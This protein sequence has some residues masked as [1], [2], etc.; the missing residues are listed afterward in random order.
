MAMQ[1]FR[2]QC[3][4]DTPKNNRI[5]SDHFTGCHGKGHMLASSDVNN[6]ICSV[7]IFLNCVL[8]VGGLF[9]SSKQP[10]VQM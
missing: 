4:R 8:K 1:L 9:F 2:T 3:Y 7:Q 5:F 10:T 6:R